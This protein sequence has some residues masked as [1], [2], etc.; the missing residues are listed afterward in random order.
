MDDVEL[1]KRRKRLGNAARVERVEQRLSQERL[2]RMVGTNQTYISLL[3][4][5]EINVTFNK[6]CRIAEALEVEVS[7]LVR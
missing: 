1:N 5:G 4:A 6:L 3:E 7:D 2:G